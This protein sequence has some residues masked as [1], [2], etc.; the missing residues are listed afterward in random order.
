MQSRNIKIENKL[1]PI[2]GEC[3]RDKFYHEG[4]EEL[5]ILLS[6]K[7]RYFETWESV[8]RCI[9]GRELEAGAALDLV[10]N[11]ANLPLDENTE[12]EAYRWLTLMV[13][14]AAK[15]PGTKIYEY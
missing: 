15:E 9:A 8:V 4:I 6:K 10:H 7:I 2:L 1:I 13:Y 12:E 14:N 5:R 3:F 11:S